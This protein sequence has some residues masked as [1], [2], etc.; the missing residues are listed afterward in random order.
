MRAILFR[1]WVPKLWV[2]KVG[3]TLIASGEN[4]RETRASLICLEGGKCGWIFLEGVGEHNDNGGIK[5]DGDNEHNGGGKHNGGNYGYS[6]KKG[7][8]PFREERAWAKWLRGGEELFA[9]E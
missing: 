4:V 8:I 5:K 2:L 3:A 9:K 6:E 1:R 7:A